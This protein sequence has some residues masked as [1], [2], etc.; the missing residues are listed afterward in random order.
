MATHLY[1]VRAAL[2]P[3]RGTTSGACDV[4]MCVELFRSGHG[5]RRRRGPLE[6]GECSLGTVAVGYHWGVVPGTGGG[7]R[8]V[9][10]ALARLRR[11]G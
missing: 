2:I 5:T 7:W 9:D 8:G 1:V 3:G 6:I 11:R 10:W 4:K